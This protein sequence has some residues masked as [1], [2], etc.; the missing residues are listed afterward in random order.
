MPLQL[1]L[2]PRSPFWIIQTTVAG[3]RVEEEAV[4]LDWSNVDLD[5]GHVISPERK[6]AMHE[7]SHSIPA[8]WRR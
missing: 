1:V 4:W 6:I 7:V 5:R 8:P 2:R 3:I